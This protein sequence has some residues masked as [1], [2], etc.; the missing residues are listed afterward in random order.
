MKSSGPTAY[1]AT[2]LAALLLPGGRLA[3]RPLDTGGAMTATD[4]VALREVSVSDRAV[5]PLRIGADGAV[6]FDRRAIAA[7]P[8]V[9]GE[10]DPLRY[11]ATLPGVSAASDYASGVSADGMGYSGTAFRLNGIPLH[12]P[13]HFGGIF[14][15]VSSPLFSSTRFEKTS[16]GSAD[17]DVAGAVA[18]M[19][20]AS[21]RP[22]RI[23]AEVN[24]GMLASALYASIPIGRKMSVACSGRVSYIDALYG[25]LLRSDNTSAK[26]GLADCDVLVNLTPTPADRIEVTAHYNS[27]RIR[28][29]DSGYALATGLRWHN[30][31][32]GVRWLREGERLEMSN[33]IY[34]SRFHNELVLDMVGVRLTAPT[35]IDEAGARGVFRAASLPRPWR[36]ST[37]YNGR[38]F[39]VRPQYA[40]LSGIGQGG[41]A[42]REIESS[43]YGS[44][45]ADA[46]VDLPGRWMVEAGASIEGYRSGGFKTVS[47]N[48]RL[49][50]TKRWRG[51]AVAFHA[52]RSRQY[53]HTVGFSDLGL[54]SNF[55]IAST[56]RVAPTACYSF[57]LGTSL[58]L[59]ESVVAGAEA[60]YKIVRDQPEYIGGV[61]DIIVPGY[62]AEDYI[63][64][65]RGYNIGGSVSLRAV[66]GPVTANASYAYTHTRRHMGGEAG[67]FSSSAE[68]RDVL[69]FSVSWRLG[70][71]WILSGAFN[72]NTGHP[73]TPVTAVYFI[74]EQLMMEYGPRNSARLP[75][76][77]RLDLGATY[78]FSTGGR[79]P[80][81]HEINFSL[82]NA[83][84][85]RNVEIRTFAIDYDDGT[86]Y[87]RDISSLYRFLP[88]IS[89]TIV[90]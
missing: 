73:Y 84:G 31:L 9:L 40:T 41:G 45:F 25:N 55:K 2:V 66:F 57:A 67:A 50:V 35:G 5:R 34:Y 36:L 38:I 51:G 54:S 15:T 16:K 56:G 13:Y 24:A 28:Y 6:S 46:A 65:T 48:P 30:A 75:D 71:H 79:V 59:T 19:E 18:A 37:G 8:R 87:R 12:F 14:S 29:D 60:F 23:S 88:S 70:A 81:R 74:G 83:Y 68:L 89:Y 49:G 77:H 11:L 27:D 44:V 76:Y 80:L 26:Y 42:E 90:L 64:S 86:F 43:F 47:A 22:E 82:I 39:L 63:R 85:R 1:M 61:L 53:L 58:S 69:R 4:T 33:Q 52:S 20:S 62:L 7:V 78:C 17:S 3:S 10:A 32:A 21:G 72:Y